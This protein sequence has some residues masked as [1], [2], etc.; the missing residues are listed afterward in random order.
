VEAEL[1]GLQVSILARLF[2]LHDTA[3]PAL[4]GALLRVQVNDLVKSYIFNPDTT[5]Q[6]KTLLKTERRRKLTTLVRRSTKACATPSADSIES[7]ALFHEVFDT[8]FKNPDALTRGF[9]LLCQSLRHPDF[10]P[11]R[12]VPDSYT[13]RCLGQS[14]VGL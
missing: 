2:L 10:D 9:R 14:G 5:S 4:D 7:A 6:I 12:T 13:C 11:L 1:S 8:V 3:I